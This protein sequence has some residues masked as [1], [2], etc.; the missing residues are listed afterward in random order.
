MTALLF[1]GASILSQGC[2]PSLQSETPPANLQA[3]L[4]GDYIGQTSRGEVYHSIVK[5][6]VPQFGGEIFYHH[7]SLHSLRGPVFQ[8][9]I[10]RFDDSGNRMRS[11][12]LLGPADGFTDEQALAESLNELPEESLL[13]FPDACQFLWTSAEGNYKAEVRRE[14]CSY[15]S[16]AFGGLVSPEMTYVLSECGLVIQEGIF[17]ED[18]TP[19]FPPSKTDN[20]RANAKTG[21]CN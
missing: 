7:I 17:R 8:R 20:R 10:Y 1:M 15:E 13:R 5:L 9:K 12:V 16:P 3:L 2:S 4:T 21:D 11:T 18:N 19:V 14:R 6:D